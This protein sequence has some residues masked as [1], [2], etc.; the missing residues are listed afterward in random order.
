VF[1][2]HEG[3]YHP[4]DHRDQ[5]GRHA[6]FGGAAPLDPDTGE[7]LSGHGGMMIKGD[8]HIAGFAR[9]KAYSCTFD[10]NGLADHGLVILGD[11]S[12]P[13]T[14]AIPFDVR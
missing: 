13:G 12:T 9:G 5:R 4:T 7:Q 14:Y 10:A 6:A 11:L 8:N 1:H 2:D 3:S